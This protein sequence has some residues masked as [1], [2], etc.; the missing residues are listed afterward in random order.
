MPEE[1]TVND[2]GEE[3]ANANEPPGRVGAIQEAAYAVQANP[4]LVEHA[5][6]RSTHADIY[7]RLE[8]EEESASGYKAMHPC[9]LAGQYGGIRSKWAGGDGKTIQRPM[10]YNELMGCFDRDGVTSFKGQEVLRHLDTFIN[11]LSL[12]F[13]IQSTLCNFAPEIM[14]GGTQLPDICKGIVQVTHTA[15]QFV[16][17][18]L[19]AF[20]LSWSRLICTLEPSALRYRC[21]ARV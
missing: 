8:T 9:D 6:G 1:T 13:T 12:P 15:I 3:E 18:S 14:T 11:G 16:H 7:R 5:R 20:G 17:D 10:P 4:E 19:A 21:I 2:A